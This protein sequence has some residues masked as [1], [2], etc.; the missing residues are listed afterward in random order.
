MQTVST[1]HRLLHE[2]RPVEELGAVLVGLRESPLEGL[3]NS[4]V[5]RAVVLLAVEQRV[6]RLLLAQVV[7]MIRLTR[8]MICQMNANELTRLAAQQGASEVQRPLGS[9]REWSISPAPQW[10]IDSAW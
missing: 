7:D 6:E 4:V 2:R 3:A 1:A 9:A 8:N 10:R 5:D